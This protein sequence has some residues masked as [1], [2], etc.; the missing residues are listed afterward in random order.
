MDIP[1][2]KPFDKV[3]RWSRPVVVTEKIDGTNGVIWISDGGTAIL[4]G[5]R[6]QWLLPNQKDNFGFARWVAENQV[7]LFKLG[8]GYHYGEWW[9][10]GIQRGYGL[11]NGEKRF[12]LFNTARW[13]KERPACCSV[14]PELFSGPIDNTQIESLLSHLEMY[15]SRAAPGFM[16]PEGIVIFH[17]ASRTLFKK[18]IKG[19]ESFKGA[20]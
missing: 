5:S 13:G 7:E 10:S 17:E 11:K 2:F 1:E 4:A 14:V 12:S 6:N 9:G 3:A 19:D 15:G 20:V 8:P 18:T 16:R